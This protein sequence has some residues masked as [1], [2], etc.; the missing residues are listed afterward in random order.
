MTDL[1][2]ESVAAAPA[3]RYPGNEKD[4]RRTAAM[5]HR[6]LRPQDGAKL[7]TDFNFARAIL[8]NPN[9]LQAGAGAEYMDLENPDQV[10]FF[11][12]DGEIHRKKRSQVARYFAPKA[13]ETRYKAVMD[14]TMERLIGDFRAKG[15]AQLDMMSFQL[16][17]EVA[18]EVVGLTNSKPIPMA[19]RIRRNFDAMTLKRGSWLQKKWQMAVQAYRATVFFQMD[20]KPAIKARKG[21]HR[22]DVISNLVEEGYSDQAILIECMTYATAGM[23]TTRE[24]IVVCAWHLFDRPELRERF[25][26]GDEADQLAILYEILRM[27]PVGGMIHR[28][29]TA[30]WTGPNGEEVKTG[31]VYAI[32]IRSVNTDE[33]A[34]GGCPFGFD[35][36]RAKQM[37]APPM[38]MSFAEGPHRCP[39]NLVAIHETRV[40]LERL[41]TVPG[42]RLATAPS[43]GWFEAVGGYE[44]HGAIVECDKS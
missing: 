38:W 36:N 23:M 4:E 10:S 32:D 24:F 39:G 5:A 43:V 28:R 19:G 7:V 21:Q 30:D 29:A 11:F 33:K 41:F 16:A 27:E 14:A 34:T 17:V 18:A 37:K 26:A 31:D 1:A 3:Y 12:L 13:I 22:D 15:R 8:R 40:F 25:L 6:H 44:L 42:V 20:V 9:M 2:Q 35:D